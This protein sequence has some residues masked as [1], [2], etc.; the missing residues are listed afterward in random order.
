MPGLIEVAFNLLCFLCE[1]ESKDNR[2]TAMTKLLSDCVG[3]C[4]ELIK[5]HTLLA[6]S[7]QG[8]SDLIAMEA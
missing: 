6:K 5:D 7:T 3:K 2:R 4:V 1:K 8:N